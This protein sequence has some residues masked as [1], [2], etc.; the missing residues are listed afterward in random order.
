VAVTGAQAAVGI[1]GQAAPLGA[2]T[3][4]RR[5]E[6]LQVRPASV[7][8]RSYVAF[9]GGLDVPL[10]LGSAS[11]DLLS[12][13]GPP[14][15]ADGDVLQVGPTASAERREGCALGELAAPATPGVLIHPG[16]RLDW[17]ASPGGTGERRLDGVSGQQPRGA[18][19][20]RSAA[21]APRWRAGK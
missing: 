14:R 21:A 8:V 11:A 10:V 17:V 2:A 15:L 5:G 19:A 16:P 6:V 18:A 3:R 7:G 9:S 13:L 12:G 1:D 4:L 20:A